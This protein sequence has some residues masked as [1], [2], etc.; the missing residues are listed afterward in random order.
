MTEEINTL[1]QIKL[2]LEACIGKKVKLRANRGRKRIIEAEGVIE[3][4]YPK[5]FVVKLDE[6]HS[7]KRMS[8]TY[9]DVLTRT[10]ELTVDDYI[11]GDFEVANL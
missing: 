4:T 9:A 2:D 6:E 3:N 8:Y 11:I 7:I 10:V 5:I 1:E